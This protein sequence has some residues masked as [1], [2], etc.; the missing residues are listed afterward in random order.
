MPPSAQPI[1][2]G[3]QLMARPQ[4]LAQSG[5]RG[6]SFTVGVA[7]LVTKKPQ[8]LSLRPPKVRPPTLLHLFGGLRLDH[9]RGPEYPDQKMGE[10]MSV[11]PIRRLPAGPTSRSPLS[12]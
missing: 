7:W 11:R 5:P 9:C 3:S 6:R 4:N 2:G 8:R 10:G 12:W 1:Q